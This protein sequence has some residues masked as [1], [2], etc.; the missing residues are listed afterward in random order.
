MNKNTDKE[1]KKEQTEPC[2]G[3]ISAVH[4]GS[5]LIRFRGEDLAAKVKGNFYEMPPEDWPVVGDYVN[6]D[7]SPS[8]PSVI[9]SVC[10]RTSFLQ[11]PD[12]AKTA[13]MPTM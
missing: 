9:R 8:G 7:R 3:R 13:A 2:T 12:S 4:K 10:E 1:L 11:R 5:F 6:F